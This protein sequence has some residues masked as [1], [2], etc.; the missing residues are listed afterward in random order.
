MHNTLQ[1]L[2]GYSITAAL[3][4]SPPPKKKRIKIMYDAGMT[5]VHNAAVWHPAHTHTQ[6][7]YR[8]AIITRTHQCPNSYCC[9]NN[10]TTRLQCSQGLF[11]YKVHNN[12]SYRHNMNMS[13]YS[14]KPI[15]HNSLW[16]YSICKCLLHRSHQ[17]TLATSQDL[18]LSSLF[19]RI[20]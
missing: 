9:E 3:Y 18:R 16:Q 7:W 11:F 2:G 10:R 15:L 19:D 14:P 20:T 6:T 12:C 8:L 5:W 13:L 4:L 1:H 17:H